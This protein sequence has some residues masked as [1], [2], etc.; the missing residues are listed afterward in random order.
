MGV[1]AAET[2]AVFADAFVQIVRQTDVERAIG[3]LQDLDPDEIACPVR[4]WDGRK[5]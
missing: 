5:Y 3:R 2:K 4:A 1:L